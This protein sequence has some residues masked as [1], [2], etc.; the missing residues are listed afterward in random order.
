MRELVEFIQFRLPVIRPS[1]DNNIL[2]YDNNITINDTSLG[3]L[4]LIVN[5]RD[6][7]KR[8]PARLDSDDTM[9]L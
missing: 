6:I 9:N 3:Y 8:Q 1:H 2:V 7:L 5:T 4:P